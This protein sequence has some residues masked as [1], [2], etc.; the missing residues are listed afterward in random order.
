MVVLKSIT[1]LGLG[2]SKV[3]SLK[4]KDS[5]K[6]AKGAKNGLNLHITA[7]NSYLAPFATSRLGALL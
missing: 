7:F 2:D 3:A 4:K 1:P 5:R 6:G